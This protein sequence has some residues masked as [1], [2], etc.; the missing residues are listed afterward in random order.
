MLVEFWDRVSIN[1]QEGMFGFAAGTK[2]RRWTG[3]PSSTRRITRQTR[4]GT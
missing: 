2:G 1:E 3:T 4:R